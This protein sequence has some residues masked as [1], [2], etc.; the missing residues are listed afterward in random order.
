MRGDRAAN[1]AVFRL[2][3]LRRAGGA[4]TANV[5]SMVRTTSAAEMPGV[6]ADATLMA[7]LKTKATGGPLSMFRQESNALSAAAEGSADFMSWLLADT[8][9]F[10][11]VRV[12]G[13]TGRASIVTTL[14]GL[15]TGWAAQ[16]AH[17]MTLRNAAAAGSAER[18]RIDAKIA[19]P[20]IAATP[21]EAQTQLTA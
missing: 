12:L 9:T 21:A 3:L 17:L 10:E 11:I 13:A 6:C 8:T 7:F 1:H 14:T 5:Q 16:M 18:A 20:P 19:E 15:P 2:N 4:S